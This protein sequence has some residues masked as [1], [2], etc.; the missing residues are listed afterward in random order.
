M[1]ERKGCVRERETL[2]DTFH[3]LKIKSFTSQ[4][5]FS[6]SLSSQKEEGETEPQEENAQT[7]KSKNKH[8]LLYLT[9][10]GW[11]LAAQELLK[12]QLCVELQCV[13]PLQLAQRRK[14]LNQ[15]HWWSWQGH[16]LGTSEEQRWAGGGRDG[17][18]V[19]PC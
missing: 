4:T 18:S 1:G 6:S 12:P 13:C 14:N 9:S 8:A 7:L 5:I 10:W 17:A 11:Q 2:K 3:F 16:V 19:L 15:I